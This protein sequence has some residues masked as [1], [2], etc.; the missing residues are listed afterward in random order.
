MLLYEESVMNFLLHCYFYQ[1]FNSDTHFSFTLQNRSCCLL[2]KRFSSLSKEQDLPLNRHNDT[3][4]A[5][6]FGAHKWSSPVSWQ[7]KARCTFNLQKIWNTLLIPGTT[8]FLILN[9]CWFSGWNAI[10]NVNSP[11]WKMSKQSIFIITDERGICPN[12]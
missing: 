11:S 10:W 5:W 6:W 1:Y 2:T 4:D 12:N 3:A 9:L 8:H 7:R